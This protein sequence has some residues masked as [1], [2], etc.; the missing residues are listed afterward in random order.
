[1]PLTWASWPDT[2]SGGGKASFGGLWHVAIAQHVAFAD[3]IGG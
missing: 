3:A 2:T 1:L